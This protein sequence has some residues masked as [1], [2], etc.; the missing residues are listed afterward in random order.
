MDLHFYSGGRGS[1]VALPLTTSAPLLLLGRRSGLGFRPSHC[2][3]F[4][5]NMYV[6]V[7]WVCVRVYVCMYVCNPKPHTLP[8]PQ[9]IHL[10]KDL[11]KEIIIKNPKKGGS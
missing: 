5:R 11:Y 2:L 8:R 4:L 1:S 10:F 3:R 7:T 6:H 9:R